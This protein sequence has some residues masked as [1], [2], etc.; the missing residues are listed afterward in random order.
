[1]PLGWSVVAWAADPPTACPVDFTQTDAF[2]A[3]VAGAGTCECA[4]NITTEP[5]VV[6]MLPTYYSSNMSCGTQGATLNVN[7]TACTAI[8]FTGSLGNYYKSPPLPVGGACT[9]A[10][11]VDAL[12]VTK[13]RTRACAPSA[14]CL[15]DVCAGKTPS[16]FASCIQSDG[17]VACP[18][19]PFTKRTLVMADVE[20]ACSACSTCTVSGQC[21]NP[22]I[23]FYSDSSCQNE[24][25]DLPSNGTCASTGGGGSVSYFRYEVTV[26]NKACAATGPKTATL[27]PKGAV[28]VCC[29]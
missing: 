10:A 14:Q 24:V 2:T 17:D 18:A 19:G 26:Q 8:G 21:T 1:V 16:G 25:A 9:G 4:C 13:T 20:V 5:C 6:G 12:K 15:E 3:P 27:T 29:R 11:V 28:T 23:H 7:G 22:R